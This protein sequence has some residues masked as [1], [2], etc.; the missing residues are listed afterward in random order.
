VETRTRAARDRDEEER[1][2]AADAFALERDERRVRRLFG[3]AEDQS[4]AREEEDAVE[5]KPAEEAA[6]LEQRPHRD[7]RRDAAVKKERVIPKPDAGLF[8]VA[9]PRR[10]EGRRALPEPNGD[11]DERDENERRRSKAH[12]R[13]L[14]RDAH[15]KSEQQIEHRR[16]RDARA[17]DDR[18]V[19]D[20]QLLDEGARGD[21]GERRNDV[22][23]REPHEPQEEKVRGPAHVFA[24]DLRDA[25]RAVSDGGDERSEVV[26]RSDE[27]A[28]ED[29]PEDRRQPTERERRRDRPD[30][31]P[32][33]GDR[34]KMLREEVPAFGRD[35][36]LSVFVFV[37]GRPLIGIERELLREPFPVDAIR[38]PKRGGDESEQNRDRHGAGSY[39]R[40]RRFGGRRALDGAARDDDSDFAARFGF[41]SGFGGKPATNESA[42]SI[43]ARRLA[44]SSIPRG[45]T[46]TNPLSGR[47]VKSIGRTWGRRKASA[48]F[49]APIR[50]INV[51]PTTPTNMFPSRRNAIPPNMRR[52]SIAGSLES[53][54]RIRRAKSSS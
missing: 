42:R 23:E 7:D 20:R 34:R 44:S 8:A 31:G 45:S 25:S 26:E 38:D 47:P 54:D 17:Q 49:A 46:Y 4:A 6:R 9:E 32:R 12:A 43:H 1:E 24:D 40:P 29:D 27:D 14:E 16:G 37:R 33:R 39:A 51:S 22:D 52:S 15:R 36:V 21:V 5:K 10:R 28:A 18:A 13:K 3:A 48:S 35:V 53:A 11:A 41:F 2:E 19:P 50:A 30:D